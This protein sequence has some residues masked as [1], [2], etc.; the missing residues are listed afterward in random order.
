VEDPVEVIIKAIAD[1]RTLESSEALAV[2][3]NRDPLH[4]SL[5]ANLRTL[6]LI[7]AYFRAEGTTLRRARGIDDH[8]DRTQWTSGHR[9]GHLTI[10]TII[11]RGTSSIVY[12]AW[13]EELHRRV[14]LKVFVDEASTTEHL[15][16]GQA[17]ASVR[18]PSLVT[19]FGA[20]R[21]ENVAGLWMEYIDGFTL[22]ETL[23]WKGPLSAR[24]ATFVVADVCGAL[25]ALHAAGLVH[26]DLK[27][28]NV[29]RESGG[30]IVLMDL[31][32]SGSLNAAVKDIGGTPMYMAP[33]LF[34]GQPATP[35]SDIY[36]VGVLMFRLLTSRYPIEA[37]TIDALIDA[38]RGGRRQ[39]LNEARPGV[40]PAVVAV[41]NRAMSERPDE[42]FRSAGQLEEALNGALGHRSADSSTAIAPAPPD[43]G[44]TRRQVPLWA[45]LVA[46]LMVLTATVLVTRLGSFSPK[47]NVVVF[48]GGGYRTP[49]EMPEDLRQLLGGYENLALE[50]A[51]RGDWTS[52]I[53][54]FS[55]MLELIKQRIGHYSPLR[56]IVHAQ[57]GWA[58]QHAGRL[59]EAKDDYDAALYNFSQE[60]GPITPWAANIYAAL[61]AI[62]QARGQYEAAAES[63]ARAL[64]TR[65]KLLGL[66]G[67]EFP[68]RPALEASLRKYS[69]IEDNDGDWI[70]DAAEAALGL[71]PTRVDT[72]ND[73]IPD[74]EELLGPA[75]WP[76]ALAWGV[77]GELGHTVAF[78]A[79]AHPTAF[80]FRPAMSIDREEWR[81]AGNYPS[82]LVTSATQGHYLHP[83]PR[84]TAEVADRRGWRYT[85]I[86]NA[87]GGTA[88]AVLDRGPNFKRY[89]IRE[90]FQHDGTVIRGASTSVIPLSTPVAHRVA[91]ARPSSPLEMRFDP[92]SRTAGIYDNGRRLGLD[93][94][95]HTQFR[96]NTG[97][98]F[99]VGMDSENPQPSVSA[100]FFLVVFEVH[101]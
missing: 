24:E 44:I 87:H 30:R 59:D 27:A 76:A 46:C 68:P 37:T 73:G 80:G 45:A 99:G 19:V 63:F 67:A 79:A 54:T 16:E 23:A 28:A 56:S 49:Y 101:K 86:A 5:A 9:F 88:H 65:Q 69:A 41:V 14:A 82:L 94:T 2:P 84:I 96:E 39:L 43:T 18:H 60:L 72:D 92:H 81:S 15:R 10:E 34:A 31:G 48:D 38:H 42:R 97:V 100:E 40:P 4:K 47:K 53:A 26:R 85:A 11:G 8:E 91:V 29:M 25:A 93:Y 32:S 61:A 51:E 57:R 1:G 64:S 98:I 36:A 12:R 78:I 21:I 52:A 17:L 13:D 66:A 35:Q 95:G 74:A 83:V 50:Q 70:S 75:S 77:N 62:H 58:N 33:E 3:G 6:S 7:E 55:P 20:A 71:D 89:D 22:E 90:V